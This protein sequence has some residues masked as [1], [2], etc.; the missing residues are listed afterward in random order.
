MTREWI[1]GYHSSTS[2]S[3]D[4]PLI[5]FSTAPVPISPCVTWKIL[6]FG[7]D[8]EIENK[9]SNLYDSSFRVS[10]FIM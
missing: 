1:R 8:K 2:Q 4:W 7:I 9:S 5:K 6:P 10:L 3:G